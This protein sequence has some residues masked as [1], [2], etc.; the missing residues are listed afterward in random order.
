MIAAKKEQELLRVSLGSGL[1]SHVLLLGLI[2]LANIA[3]GHENHIESKLDSLGDQ[4]NEIQGLL[5]QA[6]PQDA[7]AIR[8]GLGSGW[9]WK[10]SEDGGLDPA[11][12][13]TDSTLALDRDFRTV[14]WM[15]SAVVSA[16]PWLETDKRVLNIPLAK[17]GFVASVDIL[18]YGSSE[19]GLLN[20]KLEGGLGIG[21]QLH[22][23]LA[24]AITFDQF[25]VRELRR[26]LWEKRGEQIV[27]EDEVVLVL[28]ED[29]DSLF[30]SRKFTGISFKVVY[31]LLGL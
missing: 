13:P 25:E 18:D 10:E 16:Q 1:V 19:M 23:S 8:I 27:V 2:G 21:F 22:D 11:V 26:D 14:D 6:K 31:K 15:L 29:N 30:R 7:R 5:G 9:R 17:V 28:D 20:K 24:F 12:I 3:W 4:L